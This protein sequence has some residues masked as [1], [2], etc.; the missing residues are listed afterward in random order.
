ME[1]NYF[2]VINGEKISVSEGIYHA[3]KRPLWMERKRRQI[4]AKHEQSLEAL[5]DDGLDIPSKEQQVSEIVDDKLR[6]D[7]LFSALAALPDDERS[8]ID[9]LFF[10]EKSEREAAHEIGVTQQAI[11]KRKNRI[12]AKLRKFFES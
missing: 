4:R 8:I 7:M 10:D 3:F 5:L 12:L 2:I 6:L 11:N 9:I 1:K